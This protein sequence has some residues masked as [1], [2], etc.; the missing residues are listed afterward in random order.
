MNPL[1]RFLILA[2]DGFSD[3][4]SDVDAPSTSHERMK[5]IISSWAYSMSLLHPPKCV[6][7]ALPWSK[8]D[9]MA[10]RLLRIALGGEDRL[11]VSKVLTL[12]M[13]EAW[14][15]DTSIVVMTI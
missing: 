9:N 8:G 5:R 1:P 13:D 3:L 10:L 2:S 14:I 11:T 4:C 6:T 15:D 7:D 12:D